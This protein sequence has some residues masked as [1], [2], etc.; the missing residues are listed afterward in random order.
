MNIYIPIE[1]VL[2]I[3]HWGW[4][5]IGYGIVWT[6]AFFL[7]RRVWEWAAERN[8]DAPALGFLVATIIAWWITIPF[9]ALALCCWLVFRLWLIVHPEEPHI[10]YKPKD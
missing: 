10:P 6:V 9:A 4:P 3:P 8:D 7:P 5:L 1:W 2:E